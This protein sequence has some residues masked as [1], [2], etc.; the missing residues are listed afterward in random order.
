[1]LVGLASVA[2]A[3]F[4][5]LLTVNGTGTATGTWNVAITGIA[6]DASSSG[7]TNNTPPTSNATSATFDATLPYPGATAVYNVTI[8]NTGNVDAKLSSIT[9]LTTLNNTAPS[10][11]KYAVTGVAADD[12][13]AAGGSTT[14]TVTVSWDAADTTTQ[15]TTHSKSAT[16]DFNYVQTP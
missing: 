4:T 1:M 3:A 9:N 2:Y 6:L 8:E 10:Y 14:A 16:I 11:I 13:L 12:I 15:T 7:G 5:Q